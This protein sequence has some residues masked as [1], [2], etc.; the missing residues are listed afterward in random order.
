MAEAELNTPPAR[1]VLVDLLEV[2]APKR[3]KVQ[4]AR[5]PLRCPRCLAELSGT[6]SCEECS[7]AGYGNAGLSACFSQA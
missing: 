2:T 1:A 4:P 3:R 6:L 7:A 5:L